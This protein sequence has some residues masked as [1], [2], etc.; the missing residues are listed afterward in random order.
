MFPHIAEYNRL[1]TDEKSYGFIL[2][3]K[4]QPLPVLLWST[5]TTLK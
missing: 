3:E 1:L 2:K 4:I 5:V